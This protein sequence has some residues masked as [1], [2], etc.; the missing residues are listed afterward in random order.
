MVEKTADSALD[1][2][3]RIHAIERET[4]SIYLGLG[5]AFQA[6]KSA[7]DA[8]ARAADDSVKAV[9]HEYRGGS[10]EATA[11][12]RYADFMEDANRFFTAAARTEEDFLSGVERGIDKLSRLDDIIDRVRADSEEM[13]I[14]SLNAMTVALKSGAAGRAF[15][16]ITDELKRLSGRTI[17]H[18]NDLSQAGAALL[19]QLAALRMELS[20]LSA[21]QSTFF[22]TVREALEGGFAE[23]D[24]DVGAAAAA[25][26]ALGDEASG[27]RAPI[28]SIMQEVQLQ[29]IIRQSLDHVRLSLEAAESDQDGDSDDLDEESAFLVE[30][31]RLS[32]S[33]LDDVHNQVRSSFERF[34]A[35]LDSVNAVMESVEAKRGAVVRGASVDAAIRGNADKAASFLETKASAVGAASTI[36]DSVKRLDERFK[37]M[38]AILARFNSIVTAS[39]IETARNRA[40]S[41]V[42]NTVTGMMELTERLSADVSSAGDVTRSFSKALSSGVAEYIADAEEKRS[43]LE[44]AIAKLQG[45]F[46]RLGESRA[47][48]HETEANFRPF[49]T[50]FAEAITGADAAMGRIAALADE[51]GGM[52]DALSE[53]AASIERS[54]ASASGATLALHNERLKTIVDRFTIFT[55]KQ[56]AV[57]IARLDGGVEDEA[58]ESGDVTLF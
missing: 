31:S 25:I 5:R 30:I 55:H 7:V 17:K 2:V 48:L 52:R 4:E 28:S 49:S 46:A 43:V 22:N 40:L 6:I 18:A 29:D 20:D 51:L 19:A 16:V 1:L 12:R 47:R 39:R 34:R 56:T 32:A 33:L 9:L 27:V 50:D 37:A 38:N 36:A 14:V 15:S 58:A 24:A 21:A 45:E 8:S 41:I 13:E 26:R 11:R 23:L 54:G 3:E 10:S 44:D 53:Y 42:S 57:R 35:S